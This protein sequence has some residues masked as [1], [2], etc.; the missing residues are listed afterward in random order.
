M[1][2]KDS[3]ENDSYIIAQLNDNNDLINV[4]ISNIDQNI[5]KFSKVDKSDQSTILRNIGNDIKSSQ[6][7]LDTMKIEVNSIKTTEKE[8][9]YKTIIKEKE[10]RIKEYNEKLINLKN[11]Q[12]PL[13]INST[14]IENKDGKSILN[15][16]NRGDEILN[17]DDRAIGN[18][19]SKVEASKGIAN[20]VK[21][22]LN[23]QLE[24]L[25][26]TNK[27]LNEIDLSV[28]RANKKMKNMLKALASDKFILGFIVIIILLI[29]GIVVLNMMSN[30]NSEQE[31]N[32]TN[33]IYLKKSVSK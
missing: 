24:L 22:E 3:I 20:N 2:N 8:S 18:M 17:D 28:G 29:I 10:G 27:N 23:R 4:Y 13:S 12:C 6:A 9:E 25:D 11:I 33:D 19:N 1:S 14:M 21:Q 26:N 30:K 31:Y 15:M 5:Q 7:I 16:M 32:K